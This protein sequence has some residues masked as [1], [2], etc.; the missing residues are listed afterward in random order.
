MEDTNKATITFLRPR[1]GWSQGS[2]SCPPS[3][4]GQ[5]GRQ[6][7][8]VATTQSSRGRH[9]TDH[10]RYW[11][12]LW[13]PSQKYTSPRE[14]LPRPSSRPAAPRPHRGQSRGPLL[15]T[16]SLLDSVLRRT[17][18]SQLSK[19]KVLRSLCWLHFCWLVPALQPWRNAEIGGD[20]L[21][22]TGK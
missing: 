11:F 20:N 5:L 6:G 4:R 3:G 14:D 15:S 12:L 8:L 1:Q 21:E 22:R 13:R 9:W 7:G 19:P 17:C 10:S 2:T 16:C 18:S